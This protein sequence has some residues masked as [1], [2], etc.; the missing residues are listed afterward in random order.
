MSFKV[1]IGVLW[2][3]VAVMGGLALWVW[4]K[5][6]PSINVWGADLKTAAESEREAAGKTVPDFSLPTLEPFR[7]EWGTTLD[8]QDFA[9]KTP[10]LI[11]FWASWCVPCRE[12]AALLEAAWKTYGERVQ[13]LGINYRDQEA[14]A[15]DFIEEF[16]HNF[17]SG[18]D[19]RGEAALDFGLFGVPTTYFVD[20]DGTIRT[21]KVGEIS[22][23]ELESNLEQLLSADAQ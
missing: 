17:P 3:L 4:Q 8:Y 16:G 12:E 21:V 5:P 15:L 10:M 23:D 22:A 14:D 11:N 2:A 6:A 18:A 20:R 13:F 7:G 1:I 19:P 9:G